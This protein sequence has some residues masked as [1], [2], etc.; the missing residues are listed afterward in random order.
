[1]WR[2]YSVILVLTSVFAL[3]SGACERLPPDVPQG[4]HG[5]TATDWSAE[6]R[7]M[8]I[9]KEEAIRVAER[10]VRKLGASKIY[11]S[12]AAREN[13]GWRVTVTLSPTTPG[14]FTVVEVTDAGEVRSVVAGK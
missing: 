9:S 12:D 3:L 1:M 11:Q 2:R 13:D 5:E 10:E 7:T 6:G 14:G 4:T 8:T